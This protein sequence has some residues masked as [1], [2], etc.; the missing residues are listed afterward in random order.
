M[1][2]P[3]QTKNILKVWQRCKCKEVVA[4]RAPPPR[5]VYWENLH[6]D[7]F[8]RQIGSI[9]VTVLLACGVGVALYLV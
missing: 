9:S 1:F 6:L 7:T 8:G 5:D 4:V 2:N 3:K